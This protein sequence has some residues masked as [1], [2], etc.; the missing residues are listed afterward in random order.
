M[1]C[2]G[3]P[4]TKYFHE[5]TLIEDAY[6]CNALFSYV[7]SHLIDLVVVWEKLSQTKKLDGTRLDELEEFE[8]ADGNV[9]N[10][11]TYEDLKRQGLL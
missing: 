8:D 9:F 1:R 7:L 2:L 10:K 4:N 3:I 5:I 11:K 6:A